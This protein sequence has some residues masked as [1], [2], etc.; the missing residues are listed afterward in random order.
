MWDNANGGASPPPKTYPNMCVSVC[1]FERTRGVPGRVVVQHMDPVWLVMLSCDTN[2]K[3]LQWRSG[4][5]ETFS[6]ARDH[7]RRLDI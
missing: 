5:L 2:T 6:A 1:P 4:R 7:L 3:S